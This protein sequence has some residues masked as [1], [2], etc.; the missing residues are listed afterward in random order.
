MAELKHILRIHDTEVNL[1]AELKDKQI[2]WVSDLNKIMWRN[3]SNYYY[4]DPSKVFDGATYTDLEQW[5]QDS[6]NNVPMKQQ[7]AGSGTIVGRTHFNPATQTEFNDAL[8]DGGFIA[9]IH[10][11]S[12]S[13]NVDFSTY[14]ATGKKTFT[15]QLLTMPITSNQTWANGAETFFTGL[16]K[17]S[18]GGGGFVF[19]S[20]SIQPNAGSYT[21]TNNGGPVYVRALEITED[22][23]IAGTENIIYETLIDN[24]FTIS[25]SVEQQNWYSNLDYVDLFNDQ[26]V[27]GVKNFVDGVETPN[28]DFDSNVSAG[29]SGNLVELKYQNTISGD[30]SRVYADGLTSGVSSNGGGASSSVS[31]SSSTGEGYT[32]IINSG[33]GGSSE[34]ARI[35][36]RSG[37]SGFIDLKA[38]KLN[39]EIG[40]YTGTPTMLLAINASG[41]VVNGGSPSS[42]GQVDSV[43]STDSNV[44]VDNIDPANPTLSAPNM[45][46]T[47]V[48]N[49][50]SAIQTFQEK[51]HL[52]S[53]PNVT[54]TAGDID[55][56]GTNVNIRSGHKVFGEISSTDSIH[57]LANTKGV[58]GTSGSGYRYFSG[59][60]NETVGGNMLVYGDTQGGRLRVGTSTKALWDSVKFQI[61]EEL[62]LQ[63]VTDVTTNPSNFPVLVIDGDRVKKA[64][65]P[66]GG[67]GA[68]KLKY[69]SSTNIANLSAESVVTADTYFATKFIPEADIDVNNFDCFI[70]SGHNTGDIFW[71]IYNEAGTTLLAEVELSSG[72]QSDGLNTSPALSST[73]SLTGGTT[74]WI[75]LAT[76][77]AGSMSMGNTTGFADSELSKSAYVS[78]NMSAM[79]S[80][81]AGGTASSTRF[82]NAVRN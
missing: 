27:E 80:S 60:N 58:H 46:K 67:G 6:A 1:L 43:T 24:G 47:N 57:L 40:S 23:T 73:L 34:E 55:F 26:D 5:V 78:F 41:D 28:V 18:D 56:D 14:N 51:I 79:P 17:K 15:G 62:D 72:S 49:N 30:T 35:S 50:F 13:Y 59:G 61:A 33:A 44:V 68:T 48:D 11:N 74:Y 10:L 21:I 75:A 9:E 70:T 53:A 38:P 22:I 81:I 25:G 29:G 66:S 65:F 19:P 4:F 71:G 64:N 77:S 12:A 39:L 52:N 82:Y 7:D 8:V 42:L 76:N 69:Q 63:S 54:P 2:A 31:F 16:T 37:A 20:L 45:A 3:G 32:Q 36:A